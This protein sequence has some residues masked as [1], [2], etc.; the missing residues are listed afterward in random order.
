MGQQRR[1]FGTLESWQASEHGGFGF[2]TTTSGGRYFLHRKF[3]LSGSPTPGASVV[4]EVAP[5]AAGATKSR[6]VNAVLNANVASAK[7]TKIAA[8]VPVGAASKGAEA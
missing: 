2:V 8:K 4:F 6:A 7:E 3:I 1:I 5:P